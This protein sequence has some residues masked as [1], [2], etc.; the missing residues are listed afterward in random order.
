MKISILAA[1]ILLAVAHPAFAAAASGSF[2]DP[3]PTTIK[4]VVNNPDTYVNKYVRLRG[5]VADCVYE[6][7]FCP[8]EM[9][10][11]DYEKSFRIFSY[12]GGSSPHPNPDLNIFESRSCLSIG[13]RPYSFISPNGKSVDE[14]Y[15]D[16]G[17]DVGYL[18]SY[19]QTAKAVR[20]TVLSIRARVA[21]HFPSSRGLGPIVNGRVQIVTACLHNCPDLYDVIIDGVYERK[22]TLNGL[23][24]PRLLI[25]TLVPAKGKEAASMK[26]ALL[27]A[28]YKDE[29]RQQERDEIATFKINFK[30]DYKNDPDRPT[31]DGVGCV[32]SAYS[33]EAI[34]WPKQWMAFDTKANGF[35]C[36]AMTKTKQGWLLI[37][38]DE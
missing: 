2:D 15:S 30:G 34:I 14:N 25:G 37:P 32:A 21:A 28:G 27:D 36:W 35:R 3:I 8:E 10:Q 23:I 4:D 33:D 13:L 31:P 20:F 5:Q 22:S 16:E 7:K 18:Y 26:Q 11:A 17:N 12:Y 29:V 24:D 38:D 1:I 19:N 6:C 9:T